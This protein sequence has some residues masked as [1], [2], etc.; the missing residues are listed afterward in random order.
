MRTFTDT[1]RVGA[2][3]VDA[4]GR[5]H[6]FSLARW[7]QETAFEDGLDSGF[8]AEAFWIIRRLALTI[9]RM[10][11]FPERLSIETW[12][13]AKAKTVAERSSRIRGDAGADVESVAIWVHVDPETRLPARLPQEF[14]EIYGPSAGD[15]KA[16]S[17]L[18]HPAEP[19]A[20]A[21][22][23]S[24]N[25][26]SSDIDLAGHVSNL[27]Y[28][29]VAEEYLDLSQ[30]AESSGGPLVL[31]AEFRAGVGRGRAIVHRAGTMLWI[32]DQEG[33]LAATLAVV[34]DPEA[35]DAPAGAGR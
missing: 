27:W 15:R 3:D 14:E 10:P 19:P 34:T 21:E 24:W 4:D 17:S 28:W 23:L 11:A 31:E 18:R 33:T 29:Q 32:S 8:G 20:G 5:A 22:E 35:A 16:R 2:A 25:F 26:G 13:S 1:H 9:R 30:P 12:C 7:L 6:P